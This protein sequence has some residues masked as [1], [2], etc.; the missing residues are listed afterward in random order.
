MAVQ[1]IIILYCFYIGNNHWMCQGK[2][3]P[4]ISNWPGGDK[5]YS[6]YG[7]DCEKKKRPYMCVVGIIMYL[8][9]PNLIYFL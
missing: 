3:C 9:S 8:Q 5:D 7:K 6:Y 2:Y 1:E 4:I